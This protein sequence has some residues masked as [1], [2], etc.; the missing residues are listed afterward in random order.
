LL[1]REEGD[2]PI[3]YPFN[4]ERKKKGEKSQLSGRGPT[5]CPAAI[6]KGKGFAG[7]WFCH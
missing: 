3:F 4:F 2:W 1:R 6:R 7:L 5:L